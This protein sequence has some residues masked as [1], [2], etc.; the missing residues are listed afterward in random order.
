MG[1]RN[2]P[3]HAPFNISELTIKKSPSYPQQ[4]LFSSLVF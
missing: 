1:D 2:G 3:E 4:G